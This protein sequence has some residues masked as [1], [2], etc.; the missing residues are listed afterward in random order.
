MPC[1]LRLTSVQVSGSRL[2]GG[3]PLWV[4]P[5]PI[6][7]C[8]AAA[9]A[10]LL[11]THSHTPRASPLLSE[12]VTQCK[13]RRWHIIFVLHVPGVKELHCVPCSVQQVQQQS[14]L[15]YCPPTHSQ[16]HACSSS[17]PFH[18]GHTTAG[19]GIPQ[20][21]RHNPAASLYAA[22]KEPSCAVVPEQQPCGTQDQPLKMSNGSNQHDG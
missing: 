17:P 19:H 7:V 12:V 6:P 20:H 4:T 8:M 2:S 14:C 3:S 1:T 11:E 16:S 15:Q 18:T 21:P 22:L 13:D 10:P 9:R 5:W